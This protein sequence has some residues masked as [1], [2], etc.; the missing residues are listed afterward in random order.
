[1]M[2]SWLSKKSHQGVVRS[3]PHLLLENGPMEHLL[4]VPGVGGLGVEE[5]K[6]VGVDQET[7]VVDPRVVPVVEVMPSLRVL[8]PQV[9]LETLPHPR[10]MTTLMLGIPSH[11]LNPDV[12]LAFILTGQS[13]GVN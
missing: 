2:K 13:C 6:V 8:L 11:L 4:Q 3:G 7:P 9:L 12:C 1:M 10:V 5:P